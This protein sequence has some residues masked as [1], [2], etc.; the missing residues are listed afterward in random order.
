VGH[1]LRAEPDR[2]FSIL[3]LVWRLE[4]ITL[5]QGYGMGPAIR[6]QWM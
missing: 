2:A 3:G 5:I 4:Q 6:C 1:L